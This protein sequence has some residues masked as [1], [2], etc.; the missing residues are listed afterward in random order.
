M[1]CLETNCDGQGKADNL[2]QYRRQGTVKEVK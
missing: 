1:I 2:Q